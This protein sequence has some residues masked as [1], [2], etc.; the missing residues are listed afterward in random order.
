MQG[1]GTTIYLYTERIRQRSSH[2]G[3]KKEIIK[4]MNDDAGNTS[5]AE[6]QTV[7]EPD[8]RD[9][10]EQRRE[11][12][13]ECREDRHRHP[14][15]GLFVGLVLV[16]LGTLFLAHQQDWI[17]GENWW[18]YLVI[19]LGSIFI[20]SGL[21]R[22]WGQDHHHGIYWRFIVGAVL[23]LVG[24]LSILSVSHWWPL[25]LILAGIALLFRFAVRPG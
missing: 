15:Q 9:W 17:S 7:H 24:V 20:I 11:I 2:Y 22:Y 4:M 18:E 3:R 12:R 13:R 5:A 6:N 16:L 23:I 8:G 1:V 25:V 14:F 10:R 21:T 19:G